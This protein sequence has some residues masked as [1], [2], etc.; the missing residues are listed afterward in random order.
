MRSL[1]RTYRTPRVLDEQV[2]LKGYGPQPIRQLSVMELG[3]EDPTV[4]V[5]ND[6][7][8]SPATL[9]TRY[10]QRMPIENA[11]AE[12]IHFFHIDA[13]S[14]MVGLKVDFD[15][16][17]TLMGSALYRLL[18]QHLADE[19][20][21]AMAK[22]LFTHLLD[23]GGTIEITPQ[24]IIVTLDKHAHNS[25]LL[26]SGLADRPTPMPWLGDRELVLDFA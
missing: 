4:I 18:A 9:I 21:H 15:L 5:T 24:Q 7:R 11:I 14:S 1:S 10:A 17:I 8:S 12:A 23:I 20:R 19:Y 22:S 13:L 6:F 16:Q 2:H 25:Y 26:D 3:H